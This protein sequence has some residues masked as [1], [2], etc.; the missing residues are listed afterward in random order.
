MHSQ[1]HL[2]FLLS[3][4]DLGVQLVAL[5]LQLLPLLCRLDARTEC[6]P[7]T[8]CTISRWRHS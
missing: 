3:F 1:A 8:Q 4:V 5:P 7:H 6:S 2:H